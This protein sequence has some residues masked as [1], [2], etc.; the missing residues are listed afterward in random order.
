[1]STIKGTYPPAA[2]GDFYVKD[3]IAV[4]H[5]FCIGPKHV[6]HAAD[7]S[8]G[9]LGE[10]SMRSH[11]CYHCGKPYDA[12]EQV[13]LVACKKDPKTNPAAMEELQAWL[14]TLLPEV[15]AN[16]YVGFAF[17]RDES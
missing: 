11:P 4:P 9:M 14:K 1:M 3:T 6:A 8:L 15:Q 10:A 2:S 17:T 13:L 12:H 5:P 16:G 7:K